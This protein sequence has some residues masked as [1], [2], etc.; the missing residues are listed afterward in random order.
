MHRNDK[1]LVRIVSER[2]VSS[3]TALVSSWGTAELREGNGVGGCVLG[4]FGSETV[5]CHFRRFQ[6]VPSTTVLYISA[7]KE[8]SER[9]RDIDKWFI[10]I[11]RLC[12]YRW[13]GEG[14]PRPENLLGYS[15]IIKGKA[16][17]QGKNFFCLFWVDVMFLSSVPPPGC[18]GRF[19]I[20]IWSS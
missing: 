18:I 11:G 9:Q 17:S 2:K 19:F 6:R 12:V 13:A 8:F 4:V 20:P 5:W 14:L 7:R 15:F 16:G 3:I 10:R 1:F